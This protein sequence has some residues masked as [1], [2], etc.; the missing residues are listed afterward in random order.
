MSDNEQ[1]SYLID[2]CII[3][4]PE[5]SSLTNRLSLKEIQLKSTASLCFL[6]LLKNHNKVITQ[7]ELLEFAWGD[8]HREATFN[9]YYQIIL[10]LRKALL[11]IGLEKQIITTIVRKGLIVRDDICVENMN[12]SQENLFT[13][14]LTHSDLQKNSEHTTASRHVLFLSEKIILIITLTVSIFLISRYINSKDDNFFS[15]YIPLQPHTQECQY[16]IND[17]T[18][19]ASRHEEII[20]SHPEICHDGHSIYI[21]AYP[22]IM[23]ASVLMC[24]TPVTDNTKNNC[25]SMFFPRQDK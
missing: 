10:S 13:E 14:Q 6:L 17:D 2:K 5:R 19:N 23:S 3:F 7:N 4:N 18:V 15:G 25:T 11:D 22:E 9:A 24:Q 16:F 8:S 12:V 1:L 20:R 21:T